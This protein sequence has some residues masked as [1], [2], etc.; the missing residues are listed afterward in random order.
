MGS[1]TP[2]NAAESLASMIR[3]RTSW[4]G[5]LLRPIMMARARAFLLAALF[6]SERVLTKHSLENRSFL[7][8]ASRLSWKWAESQ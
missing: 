2:Q 3:S 1:D 7:A 5:R 8:K 6:S 4:G